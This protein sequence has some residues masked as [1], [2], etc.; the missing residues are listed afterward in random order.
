[1]FKTLPIFRKKHILCFLILLSYSIKGQIPQI[2]SKANQ[3]KKGHALYK[4]AKL[5]D[6]N[7][8]SQKKK[9]RGAEENIAE[10]LTYEIEKLKNPYTGKIPN[11][12]QS[13]E[14]KFSN[15]ISSGRDLQNSLQSNNAKSNRYSYWK[16]RGP[17]NVGGRTRALAIDKTNENIIFAG[18]VS[19]GLWRS[20]N[21]GKTWRKVTRRDQ[22]PSITSIIQDPR[23]SKTNIWY[24]GTG[25]R[26]GNSA[27]KSGA[28]F[29]GTGIFKSTNGGITWQLL[30]A[31]N[32]N[33]I[34][35]YSPFDIINSMVID[36]NT[37]DL[38][39]ATL[40][41]IFRS[42]NE[43]Q[44]FEEV[45]ASGR[46]A[47]S[48]IAITSTGQLYATIYSDSEV[49]PGF[50]TSYD[51][52]N[53]TEIT[54]DFLPKTIG[55]TVMAIN[56]SNENQIYFFSQN[57]GIPTAFLL[58][59][60]QN[61]AVEYQ[62]TNLTANLP[63]YIGSKVSNL[64]LQD[65]YNMV[66][67]IHPLNPNLIILGGTNLYRSFDGFTTPVGIKNWIGGYSSMEDYSVYPSHH[68][69]QHA[70]I[71]YP[72]N[73]NKVLSAN[74]GGVFISE[75]IT[76]NTKEDEP[77]EWTSLNNGYLTTQ[78]YHVSFDPQANSD[79]LLAGF[80]DNGS[81]F[82]NSTNTTAPWEEDFGGDGNYSAIADGGLTRYVST[83]LG[84]I[85]RLNF[86]ENGKEISFTKV[87]PAG[88]TNFSFIT[89]Y[90]LDPNN[91]NVMY[92]PDGNSIWRN[93]NL[94]EIPLSSFANTKVNWIQLKN[95]FTPENTSISALGISK[96]PKANRLYY[97]T[98]NGLIYKM[99]NANL[100]DQPVQEIASGKGLPKGFVNDINVDPS[101]SDR[102]I[103]S[104]S[105]YGIQ[106]IFF[107]EN[108]GD[109]WTNISGNLEENPDGSGNGSSVR[110]TA[111]LGGSIGIGSR[112]QRVFAATSTGLYYTN[113]INGNNT[114]WYKEKFSIGNAVA[115]SV[116]TR[117]DGF[118]ALATHG[119]GV[120]SARF[121]IHANPIPEPE[122]KVVNTIDDLKLIRNTENVII[123]LSNVFVHTKGLPINLK[124]TNNN[125]DLVTATLN[126]TSLQLMITSKSIG[127]ASIGLIATAKEEQVAEGFRI[128][129]SEPIVYEQNDVATSYT[130]SQ[131][132][133]DF[134][135]LGQTA[136]DFMI[137]D[138]E[139]WTI[140]R[141]MAFGST[142]SNPTL[143]N[144]TIV[145]YKDHN[146]LPGDEVYNSGEIT[147]ISEP[148][149]QNLNLLLPEPFTI[150]NGTYWISIYAN[151]AF[152]PYGTQ[153]FWSSQTSNIR[154]ESHLKDPFDLYGVGASDWTPFS[155]FTDGIPRDQIFQI[156]GNVKD[157]K[158]TFQNPKV[159]PLIT[160]QHLDPI[161]WPNPATDTF[162]F[163]LK[164]IETM[165][166]TK[167]INNTVPLEIT[168]TDLSGKI[169]FHPLNLTTN[170][171]I[172]WDATNEASGLYIVKISNNELNKTFKILKK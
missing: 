104:F 139:E 121:P 107:T 142:Q 105:N 22:M 118:V 148:E 72:S 54:P 108:G 67:R 84:N 23:P 112:I 4:Q 47:L 43:G 154:K 102:V 152:F 74:D 134:D 143:T 62:W 110:S 151:L 86:E 135:G 78:P 149:D 56:P 147:P 166:K 89:P 5:Y 94:D 35:S 51:G 109:T 169:V 45:L 15:K 156:F 17:F 140:E 10:R 18:G 37:G 130:P 161:V 42:Q 55:R 98:N 165:M 49:N 92:L 20:I 159:D 146:G 44:S 53:W 34:E 80:Q 52:I 11:N 77:I 40:D 30:D 136:D 36:P 6:S 129:I 83:Q 46:D 26:F 163:S 157:S 120:F 114:K 65:G 119:N 76:M 41:G 79:D 16:N 131:F 133:L 91:D 8:Q 68:P 171:E 71:F 124:L 33:D 128:T 12:I 63:F 58:K 82:T 1:M 9:P 106:S 126:G 60:D 31:T 75:D 113:R 122:L 111:F 155:T 164:G 21:S 69:D 66:I 115:N 117:K 103:V 3:P 99:D 138:G 19:G 32:D 70:F 27:S 28:F 150:S 7:S 141:I 95:T 170:D 2:Q 144:A 145:I 29:A 93:N 57:N 123:D 73:P 64:N 13:L 160:L 85:F 96:F 90:I 137:P 172:T 97:G 168:I 116:Q 39:V 87:S 127:K 48:E 153:W 50:H 101:N 100:D 88:A 81:W 14:L 158:S 132:F 125:P 61:S 24:Y 167:S 25:E 162:K 59:Y 38:Y